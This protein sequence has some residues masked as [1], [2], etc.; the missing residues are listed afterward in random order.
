MT[1][2]VGFFFPAVCILALSYRLPDVHSESPHLR[3]S[4][5]NAASH[6]IMSSVLPF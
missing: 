3:T 2:A 5:M 6:T 1:S 4:E